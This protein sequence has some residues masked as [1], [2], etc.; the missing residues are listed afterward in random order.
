MEPLDE[1]AAPA[2][3]EGVAYYR[4]SCLSPSQRERAR[5]YLLSALG[6]PFDYAF[7]LS[8]D[9]SL[10]CSELVV[11]AFQAAGVDLTAD[12]ENV[13]GITLTEPAIPPDAFRQ[14]ALLGE[15]E[16]GGG[17]GPGALGV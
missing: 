3:V 7:R 15:I 6:K 12:L 14:S 13:R 4:V 2:V 9:S 8:D 11:K 5:G 16:P 10:Y 17:C 1:F